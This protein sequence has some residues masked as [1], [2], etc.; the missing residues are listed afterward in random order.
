[1]PSQSGDAHLHWDCHLC[2]YFGMSYSLIDRLKRLLTM[3]KSRGD[4]PNRDSLMRESLKSCLKDELIKH[5][6][7]SLA[8][9]L[10]VP[11]S[12]VKNMHSDDFWDTFV[13]MCG[14]P[15]S[16]PHQSQD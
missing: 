3:S 9:H 13:K 12:Y 14:Q 15:P 5:T 2:A 16:S 8:S 11:I 1:M 4:F 10:P 6:N 7:Y